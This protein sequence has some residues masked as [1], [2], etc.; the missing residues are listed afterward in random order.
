[1]SHYI[2]HC[3]C[4]FALSD[5]LSF[6]STDLFSKAPKLKKFEIVVTKANK[7]RSVQISGST[8]NSVTVSCDDN[9]SALLRLLCLLSCLSLAVVRDNRCC[10]PFFAAFAFHTPHSVPLFS[11]DYSF[12]LKLTIAAKLDMLSIHFC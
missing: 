9:R 5:G 8:A 7:C 3:M 4:W 12:A 6:S 2:V 11:V 10:V 1:M